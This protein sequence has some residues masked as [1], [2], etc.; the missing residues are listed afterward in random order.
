MKQ[1]FLDKYDVDITTVFGEYLT[2]GFNYDEAKEDIATLNRKLT[3]MG[4][5]NLLAIEEFDR[6]TERHDFLCAQREDLTR[7]MED[8]KTAIKKIDETSRTRFKALEVVNE[9]FKRFF[10]SIRWRYC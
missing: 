1:R 5:V 4:Q 7:S 8:L 10:Q 6:L 2:E 9:K 3:D